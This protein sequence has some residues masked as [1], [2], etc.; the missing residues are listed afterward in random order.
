MNATG[1]AVAAYGSDVA[2][3]NLVVDYPQNGVACNIVRNGS[4]ARR[5]AYDRSEI[6]VEIATVLR[7]ELRIVAVVYRAVIT[8]GARAHRNA[9]GL[10]Q[11]DATYYQ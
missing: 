4:V 2:P 6:D 10:I 9:I 7:R 11:T 1:C 5:Y 3:D 8:L